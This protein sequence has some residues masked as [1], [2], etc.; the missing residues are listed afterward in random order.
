MMVDFDPENYQVYLER[1]RYRRQFG[2]TPKE[3]ED[4][5]QDF[6]DCA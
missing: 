3:R 2:R 5:K 6:L 4:A 1:G